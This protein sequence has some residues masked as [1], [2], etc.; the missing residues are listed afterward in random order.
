MATHHLTFFK[1]QLYELTGNSLHP[2]RKLNQPTLLSL[3][4][5]LLPL[6]TSTATASP[7]PKK[8]CEARS[9]LSSLIESYRDTD[10]EPISSPHQGMVGSTLT[11]P[12]RSS[13]TS[14]FSVSDANNEVVCPLRNQDGS[15]CRKRCIGVSASTLLLLLL[16]PS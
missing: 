8:Y 10:Y 15:A 12:P 1:H 7:I 4:Y 11:M 16:Y 2:Q 5:S 14:S 3:L 13:L 9:S 6:C